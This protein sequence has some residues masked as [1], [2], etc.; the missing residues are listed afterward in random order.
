MMTYRSEKAAGARDEMTRRGLAGLV[1]GVGVG[2]CILLATVARPPTP[3]VNLIPATSVVLAA[4][5][6]ECPEDAPGRRV[7]RVERVDEQH[8]ACYLTLG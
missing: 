1:L 6:D 8:V 4:E 2:T 5:E 3:P 7:T